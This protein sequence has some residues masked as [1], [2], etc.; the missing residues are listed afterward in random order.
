LPGSPLGG[1]I[2][3]KKIK[4]AWP[5]SGCGCDCQAIPL[6]GETF[7]EKIKLYDY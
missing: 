2:F 1:E 4:C 5:E 6:G 3:K 7:K